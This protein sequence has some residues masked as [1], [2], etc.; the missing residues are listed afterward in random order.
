MKQFHLISVGKLNNDYLKIAENYQKLIRY[1]IKSTEI[2][3]SKKLPPEQIKQFE[4]KLIKEFLVAKSYKIILNSTGRCYT[5]TEFAK[6]IE[7][8][9]TSGR[10][11]QFLIGGAFGL[12]QCIISLADSML[13]L[14]TMTFPH[15]MAKIILLEQIYRA[16]TIIENHPY[17]K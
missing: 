16:Q 1:N 9:A 15:Q 14:S 13:S 17:H 11:V 4:A 7:E 3:Y 10:E 12:D 6:K 5:S 8:L 2:S